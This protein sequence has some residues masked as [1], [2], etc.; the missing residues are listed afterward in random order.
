MEDWKEFYKWLKLH[1][2]DVV[3]Q[4]NIFRRNKYI[5]SFDPVED[6]DSGEIDETIQRIK[7]RDFW[8]FD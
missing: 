2:Y 6:A 1:G 4:S 3:R 8:N 5:T 7:E